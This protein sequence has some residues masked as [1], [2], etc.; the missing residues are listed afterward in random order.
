MYPKTPITKLTLGIKA[1][2]N[3]LLLLTPHELTYTSPNN[4]TI[5]IIINN[6]ILKAISELLFNLEIIY[7]AIKVPIA[8]EKKLPKKSLK[9]NISDWANP[10]KIRF[11]IEIS[12]AFDVK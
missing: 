6:I 1:L 4:T 10:S 2:L 7:H 3:P 9:E 12:N 5:N 11:G 8:P